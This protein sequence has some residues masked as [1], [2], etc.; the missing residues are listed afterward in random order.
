MTTATLTLLRR[1]MLGLSV[2][3]SALAAGCV[4][5]SV[6]GETCTMD[7]ET[8]EVGDTVPSPYDCESCSCQSDGTV[9][10]SDDQPCEPPEPLGTCNTPNGPIPVGSTYE[11]PDECNTCTC[12]AEGE[13]ECSTAF[14]CGELC[15][16]E[17][18]IYTEY[19]TFPAAD[20]CNTCTCQEDGS[21]SC[22]ELSCDCDPEAEWYREYVGHS[23]AECADVDL[24]CPQHLTNFSNGCGCGCEQSAE[25]EQTYDCAP[26]AECDVEAIQ[27]ECPFSTIVL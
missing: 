26:P 2:L 25:C 20:G 8:Y 19:Q 9:V 21:V 16:Y 5:V 27:T 10:C 22:T 11:N 18:Q 24:L 1:S 6:E 3:L 4:V 23:P 13:L 15:T 17:G 12:T 7:G 14:Y